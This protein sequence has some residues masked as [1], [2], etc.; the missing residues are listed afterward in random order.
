ML[1][2]GVITGAHGIKGEVKLK[3]FTADPG[4]SPPMGRSPTATGETIEIER[5]RPQKDGFI[6]V[7]KG[8]CDRN[9]AEALDGRRALRPARQACPRPE[10]GEVYV[11]DLIGLEAVLAAMERSRR[12]D[13]V[14]EFRRR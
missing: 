4:R 1:C 5:L 13:A 14:P 10:E 12:G 8:V 6:A 2:I 11:H 3:S 7:L 9:R